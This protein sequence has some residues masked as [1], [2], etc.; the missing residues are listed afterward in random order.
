[1]D[2]RFCKCNC[3]S[4]TLYFPYASL[5]HTPL[6]L[7]KYLMMQSS[8]WQMVRTRACEDPILDIPE[9]FARRGRGQAPR[10]NAPPPLPRALVSLEQLL[11]MQN[12][13][14][15]LIVE[16]ETHRVAEHPQPQHQ[17]WDSSYSDFLAT[18]SPVFTDA[19]GPLEADNWL[20]TIESMF[21][22]LHCTEF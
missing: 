4:S 17:D 22:L 5:D 20:C 15:H 6:D 12:D 18:H 19:T 11:A 9:G 13:L 10:G 1:M 7:C 21:G 14:M 3:Y 16:N 8:L 2:V